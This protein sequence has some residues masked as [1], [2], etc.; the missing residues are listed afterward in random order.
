ML[1][2]LKLSY[3]QSNDFARALRIVEY[4]L[5]LDP[6]SEQDHALRAQLKQW[7]SRLN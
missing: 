2:N 6:G 3:I 5:V 4:G 7:L 1:N